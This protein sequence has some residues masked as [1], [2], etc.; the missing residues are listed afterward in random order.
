MSATLGD[1]MSAL[2]TLIVEHFGAKTTFGVGAPFLAF[3][4][5]TPVP[6]ETFHLPRENPD[7]SPAVALE[8]MSQ[9][10]NV[11][12]RIQD[13][14][15]FET[16]N[17]I[18]NLFEILLKGSM[19]V[20]PS[21]M[22][23]LGAVKLS[24]QAKFDSVLASVVTPVIDSF[25]PTHADPINWYDQKEA[26]NWT[27]LDLNKFDD[28]PVAPGGGGGGGQGGG[29][30]SPRSP[31]LLQWR[32]A[33]PDLQKLLKERVTTDGLGKFR[34]K[35]SVELRRDVFRVA[36][37][38]SPLP[39]PKVRLADVEVSH[40]HTV[41]ERLR[42]SPGAMRLGG[43][44]VAKPIDQGLGVAPHHIQLPIFVETPA[45]APPKDPPVGGDGFSISVEVCLVHLR[46]P[47]IADGLLNLTNWFVPTVAKG[48]F[49]DGTGA[50]SA[51]P[52]N[53]MPIGCIFIRNLK[54][55]ASWSD[56][57]K[58]NVETSSHLGAF[59]LLGRTFDHATATLAV[60]GMQTVGWICEPMPVLPP[61]DPG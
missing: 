21:A 1:M 4:M 43:L 49:S 8:Y 25:R 6:D 35:A 61:N 42:I 13:G 40:P 51:K 36:G 41:S 22:E 56:E 20:D 47:W 15:L 18:D 24:A 39:L 26:G 31:F 50:N 58:A 23:L 3:E 44:E 59:S 37:S 19:P 27:K 16:S 7:Y 48:A 45:V 28:P 14:V 32:P 60:E 2:Q 46:R 52:L 29:G 33:P 53:V 10:A 12:P 55:K 30:D 11:A 5:G 9:Q 34:E 54:I 57:D 38:P 17:R